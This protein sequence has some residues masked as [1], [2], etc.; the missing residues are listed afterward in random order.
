[1]NSFLTR[2][3]IDVPLLMPETIVGWV[4]PSPAR[5]ASAA[6]FGRELASVIIRGAEHPGLAMLRDKLAPKPTLTEDGIA[7][8]PIKGL[9]AHSPDVF[10]MLFDGVEDSGAVGKMI[11]SAASNSD[12]KGVL[13]AIDSPGGMVT[14]GYEVADS[15]RS[16][17]GRKPVVAHTGGLMCSL[18]YLIGSQAD[19]VIATRGATV[20]SI[21][22]I[23]SWPDI[24]GYLEKLGVKMEV[25]TNAEGKFKG[26]GTP[27]KPLTEAQREDMQ[28]RMDAI[29]AD[30]R[31][32]VRSKRPNVPDSAM[33]GQVM[34][35]QEAKNA[36]LIDR[37]GSQDFALSAVRQKARLR[38]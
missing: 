12:V 14:G 23:A 28:A 9:L 13:L 4:T 34:R 38:G 10:D 7:I 37:I 33:R 20:G 3:L 24:T 27:G 5:E 6:A 31:D 8:L 16:C 29:F 15:V 21:G 35:G 11:E 36:S 22:V 19:E 26:A 30:F 32:T 18:A 1:M 2:L 17:A 25:F